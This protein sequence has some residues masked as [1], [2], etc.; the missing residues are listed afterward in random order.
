MSH[1]RGIKNG[2]SSRIYSNVRQRIV[3][4]SRSHHSCYDLLSEQVV[5]LP[6][7]QYLFPSTC[8]SPVW[9]PS[10]W[11]YY[12]SV[13]DLSS[14]TLYSLS[15][16]F[17]SCLICIQVVVLSLRSLSISS[18][19]SLSLVSLLFDMDPGVCTIF[20]FMIYL[21]SMFSPSR[22]Y[23]PPHFG[24]ESVVFSCFQLFSV[25]LVCWNK[26]QGRIE[27]FTLVHWPGTL[28]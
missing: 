28:H 18:L 27:I 8:F 26:R 2:E 6:H 10:R 24:R 22:L 23:I 16:L 11:L 7:L 19:C 3:K 12:L 20:L 4:Y 13:H 14:L 15:L 5:K 17:L 25:V 21:L 9:Y 1:D